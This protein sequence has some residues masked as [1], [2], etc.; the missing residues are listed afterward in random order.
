MPNTVYTSGNSIKQELKDYNLSTL[1]PATTLDQIH[2]TWDDTSH[3]DANNKTGVDL[4]DY[5]T[6]QFL[7]TSNPIPAQG[8]TSENLYSIVVVRTPATGIEPEF[9]RITLSPT[10]ANQIICADGTFKS[11]SDFISITPG[12]GIDIRQDSGTGYQVVSLDVSTS[13]DGSVGGVTPIVLEAPSAESSIHTLNINLGGR[14]ATFGKALFEASLNSSEQVAVFTQ[15]GVSFR[16]LETIS[17]DITNGRGLEMSGNQ[18]R[19]VTP[20]T[21]T[22]GSTFSFDFTG[23]NPGQSLRMNI[24]TTVQRLGSASL[25][26]AGYLYYSGSAFSSRDI[27]EDINQAIIDNLD[28]SAIAGEVTTIIVSDASV[29]VD[30]VINELDYKTVA[31]GVADE[32]EPADSSLLGGKI[33]TNMSNGTAQSLATKI[34][35]NMNG[36]AVNTLTGKIITY[37]DTSSGATG[38]EAKMAKCV[39]DGIEAS[40]GLQTSLAD[41][42]KEELDIPSFNV[43]VNSEKQYFLTGINTSESSGSIPSNTA[44]WGVSKAV[45]TQNGGLYQTSDA[46]LKT[47][48]DSLDIDFEK[49]ATISKSKFYWKDDETKHINIG[50]SAQEVQNVYPELVSRDNI[51]GKLSVSYD[52]LSVVALAAIDKLNERLNDLE[53]KVKYLLEK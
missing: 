31:H 10:G 8:I 53:Q 40:V 25:S 32:I 24:P 12:T 21:K 22:G 50:V 11:I 44:I 39:I 47:F 41:A 15:S 1:L 26:G 37:L 2:N 16:G 3:Q 7:G 18:I 29:I 17:S 13:L 19:I 34:V 23:E 27:T 4:I 20:T 9:A 28:V 14:M 42:I 35:T 51:T 48:T 36:S 33:V 43:T 49:L 6:W 5:Y 52:K 46:T 45:Y 30:A 38:G